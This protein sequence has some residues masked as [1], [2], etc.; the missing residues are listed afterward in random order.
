M[1]DSFMKRRDFQKE[2]DRIHI[3]EE[4][5]KSHQYN[6]DLS[7]PFIG[8]WPFRFVLL[9]GILIILTYILPLH[10]HTTRFFHSTRFW[11]FAYLFIPGLWWGTLSHV[12]EGYWQRKHIWETIL[13]GL[14][15][16]L[17]SGFTLWHGLKYNDSITRGFGLVFTALNIATRYF[18]FFWLSMYR[19]LFFVVLAA[20]LALVGLCAEKMWKARL[21][22]AYYQMVDDGSA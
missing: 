3:C 2:E 9:G 7:N 16:T 1:F 22:H 11:G 18:D 17:A 10:P 14:G 20:F 13:W 19:P 4:D 5:A 21:G 15:L 8:W 12:T 6:S